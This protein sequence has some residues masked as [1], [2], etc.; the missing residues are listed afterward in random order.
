ML[1]GRTDNA[2]LKAPWHVS[3]KALFYSQSFAQHCPKQDDD[4]STYERTSTSRRQ[5]NITL[6]KK[7]C[8]NPS[9]CYLSYRGRIARIA[10][11]FDI[12]DYRCA[13]LALVHWSERRRPLVMAKVFYLWVE[14]RSISVLQSLLWTVRRYYE[15][16]GI[17]ELSYLRRTVFLFSPRLSFSS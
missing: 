15:P 7:R 14:T 8:N 5:L 1:P 16:A 4:P 2:G 9:D 10:V 13:K 3:Q 12:P 6:D 17:S 11:L